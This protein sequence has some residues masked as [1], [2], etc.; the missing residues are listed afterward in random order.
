MRGADDASDR[1]AEHDRKHVAACRSQLQ[2]T[3]PA[4][5][6]GARLSFRRVQVE[7]LDES[8]RPPHLLQLQIRF[9]EALRAIVFS[10]RVEARAKFAVRA[11]D[12]CADPPSVPLL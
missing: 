10:A 11:A 9:R 6:L 3:E 4:L 1:R 2:A 7:S 5:I 12:P 8:G